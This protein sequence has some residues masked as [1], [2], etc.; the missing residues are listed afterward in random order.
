ML[1]YKWLALFAALLNAS[2]LNA[3]P[4]GSP[5]SLLT[6]ISKAEPLR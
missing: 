2:T 3:Q 1:A 5:V 4:S 6:R